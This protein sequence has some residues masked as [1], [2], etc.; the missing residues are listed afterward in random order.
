MTSRRVR[1]PAAHRAAG[2]EPPLAS[3]GMQ[4]SQRVLDALP[5]TAP[6]ARRR[7]GDIAPYRNGTAQRS[8]ATGYGRVRTQWDRTTGEGGTGTG[9]RH[10]EREFR[11]TPSRTR[12]G[13]RRGRG[14]GMPCRA[15]Q[16]RAATG[17]GAA[18]RAGRPGG[19]ASRPTGTGHGDGARARVEPRRWRGRRERGRERDRLIGRGREFDIGCGNQYNRKWFISSLADGP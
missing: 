11:T 8:T 1:G 19:Q 16:W 12:E 18:A 6:M 3:P 17:N 10:G 9:P 13:A 15:P 4:N 7:D 2:G 5:R 14:H